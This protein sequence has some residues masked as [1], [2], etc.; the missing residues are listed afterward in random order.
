VRRLTPIQAKYIGMFY[1]EDTLSFLEARPE[2][3]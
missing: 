3:A 2:T 1:G